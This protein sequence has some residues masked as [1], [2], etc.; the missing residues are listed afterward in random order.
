MNAVQSTAPRVAFPIPGGE[1]MAGP[2]PLVV[3]VLSSIP[4]DVPA[5]LNETTCDLVEV[6][7][8]QMRPETD[9]AGTARAFESAGLP[10]ILTIRSKA[11]GGGWKGPE[12]QR[13]EL[14][15]Q[16]LTHVSAVDV[17]LRSNIASAVAEAAK[18]QGKVCI[19]SYHDFKSTPPCHE[20]ERAT[21]QAC[22]IGSI[23][24]ISTMISNQGDREALQQIVCRQW[25]IPVCVMGMG[26][27]GSETR[28]TFAARGSCLTYG[29]LDKPSAPGQFSA[30]ELVKKLSDRIP[31]YREYRLG[32]TNRRS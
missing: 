7:L 23:A 14:F 2:V 27:L 30:A 11:E 12:D 5:L 16:G 13:L 18:A 19:V 6:R 24:K 28:I 21:T 31:S 4:H 15:R 20:L 32:R 1:L 3:G 26:P 29:Y 10:V 22:R 8:D 17:E 25:P 9:W